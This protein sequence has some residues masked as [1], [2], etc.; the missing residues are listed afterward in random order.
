M[1]TKRERRSVRARDTQQSLLGE[2]ILVEQV[3]RV[4]KALGI[5]GNQLAQY[6]ERKVK[7]KNARKERV[8]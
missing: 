3:Q 8:I 5:E 7:E 6:L 1:A 2:L 4:G